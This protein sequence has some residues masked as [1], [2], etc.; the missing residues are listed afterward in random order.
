MKHTYTDPEMKKI[1]SLILIIFFLGCT[2]GFS[3]LFPVYPEKEI[4]QAEIIVT[5]MKTY[6]QDSLRPRLRDDRMTLLIGEKVSS[7]YNEHAETFRKLSKKMTSVADLQ[8]FASDP[9]NM[10]RSAFLYRILKNYPEGKITTTDRIPLDSYLYTE[11]LPLFNWTI[12]GDT[13]MFLGYRVHKATTQ[14]GGRDW[15]AWFAPEIP[16]NDGPYKFNGLPGLI[17]KIHDIRNHYA[18]EVVAI[19]TPKEITPIIFIEQP[20]IRT[21]RS[22]FFR[23]WSSFRE[24]FTGRTDVM[25]DSYSR[26]RMSNNLSRDNNPIELSP[27]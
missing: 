11:N 20:Y 27:D 17:L 23:A 1:S 15:I 4:G 5:Y 6:Q 24:S 13:T 14:F 8:A 25:P 22:G 26:N 12:T 9:A 18:F 19:E 2:P 10:P 3:Q 7:F 16:Y 21:T